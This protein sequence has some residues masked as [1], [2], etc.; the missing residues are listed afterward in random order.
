MKTLPAVAILSASVAA[1]AVEPRAAASSV[2]A[3]DVSARAPDSSASERRGQVYEVEATP[4]LVYVPGSHDKRQQLDLYLPRGATGFPLVVFV[5]GGYW[6]SGGRRY[7]SL[8]T[9]LYGNFGRALARQGIGCA[10]ISYRLAPQTQIEG[11]LDDVT[12]ALKY[13]S[14]EGRARGAGE[15]LFLAGHSAGGH[16]VTVVANDA[17]RLEA[18]GLDAARLKGVLALSPVLDLAHM[19][20]HSSDQFNRK[21]TARVFGPDAASEAARFAK[22]SPSNTLGAQMKPMLL[23]VGGRDYPYLAEQVKAQAR[24]L[25]ALSAP[26]EFHEVPG[27]SHEQIALKV[28]RKRDAVTPLMVAFVRAHAG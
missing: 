20:A 2:R 26:L 23:V 10:V 25:Q 24:R 12:A 4:D 28:D 21:V 17:A 19:K 15:A 5:H 13:V 22:F 3:P 16:L 1:Q 14:T 7:F 8:L 18:A 27:Y 6:T 9:G 11:Q